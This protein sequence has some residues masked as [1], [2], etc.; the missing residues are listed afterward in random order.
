MSMGLFSTNKSSSS[1]MMSKSIASGNNS[2]SK[3]GWGNSTVTTSPGL[4]LW[5]LLTGSP[6]TRT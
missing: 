2:N 5:L 6:L 1:W 3:T 4:T